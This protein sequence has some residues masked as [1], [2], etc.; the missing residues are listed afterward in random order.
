MCSQS[1]SPPPS[2]RL[3]TIT[4]HLLQGG[5]KNWM[6]GVYSALDIRRIWNIFLLLG[7][8]KSWLDTA[9]LRLYNFRKIFVHAYFGSRSSTYCMLVSSLGLHRTSL[10]PTEGRGYFCFPATCRA[11]L[12]FFFLLWFCC[13]FR[14]L[15]KLLGSFRLARCCS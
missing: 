8:P 7:C 6:T 9:Y 14:F 11:W 3:C 5:P 10:N 4:G 2:N 13:C 1:S 12:I 15:R